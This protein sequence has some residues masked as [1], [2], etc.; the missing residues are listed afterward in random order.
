[1]AEIEAMSGGVS[2]KPLKAIH[3]TLLPA[4]NAFAGEASNAMAI[5]EIQ[6][7]V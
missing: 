6:S 7:E 4:P 1:M 3:A 2:S 5:R